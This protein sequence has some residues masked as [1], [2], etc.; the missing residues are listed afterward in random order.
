[1]R[2]AGIPGTMPRPRRTIRFTR[3]VDLSQGIGA[4]TQMFPAYP[5]PAFT[6]W[7]TREVHGFRAEAI[8]FVS[9]TG[10]H[11]DAPYHMEPHGKT[12]DRMPL[13][14]FLAPGHVLDLH[15]A[16]SSARIGP[17]DLAAARR[18]CLS[19]RTSPTCPLWARDPSPL[20]PF[21]CRSAG[22]R[23]RPSAPSSSSNESPGRAAVGGWRPGAA[24]RRFP[25]S[26]L[27]GKP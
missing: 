17:A 26:R 16:A 21:P 7:T 24:P 5:Q 8:S 25:A 18:A 15:Q 4:D 27:P 19:S 13:A 2:F 14:G 22:R 1:M 11:V 12:I 3:L 6:Q 10:T 20:P 9:H 23:D